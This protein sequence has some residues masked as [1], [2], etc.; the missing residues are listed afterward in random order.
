MK[1]QSNCTSAAVAGAKV[2]AMPSRRIRAL[3]PAILVGLSAGI[4]L[5]VLGIQDP[6]QGPNVDVSFDI[7]LILLIVSIGI[8]LRLHA[9]RLLLPLLADRPD[10]PVSATPPEEHLWAVGSG[11]LSSAGAR[12]AGA[13][14]TSRAL[15]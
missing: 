12:E 4:V 15:W 3:T 7:G 11:Q 8:G 1:E 2:A 5:I 14:P 13:G 10:L 6:A 9:S